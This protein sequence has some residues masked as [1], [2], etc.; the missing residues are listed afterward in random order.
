MALFLTDLFSRNMLPLDEE[1]EPLKVITAKGVQDYED[2]GKS[3]LS[4]FHQHGSVSPLMS[5]LGKGGKPSEEWNA[6]E[7]SQEDLDR[8]RSGEAWDVPMGVVSQDFGQNVRG[9][10]SS[11]EMERYGRKS[12][13]AHIQPNLIASPYSSL[14]MINSQTVMGLVPQGLR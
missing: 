7:L 4:R 8:A 9:N 13:R 6:D 2:F 11:E 1:D 10:V 5:V 14:M 3:I 12:R